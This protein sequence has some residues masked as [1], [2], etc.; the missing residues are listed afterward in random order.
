RAVCISNLKQI[1][2]AMKM[3]SQDYRE[4]FPRTSAAALS[5]THAAGNATTG[6]S[7]NLLYPKYISAEKTFICPSD[8][9][10]TTE[11]FAA[12]EVSQLG[13]DKLL[14]S[15]GCSYAYAMAC[16]EQTSVDT[17]LAVDKARAVDS[18]YTTEA[19]A[20]DVA[21]LTSSGQGGINHKADGVNALYVGGHV[22][23]IP[24]SRI[25][26]AAADFPNS[27]YATGTAGWVKNP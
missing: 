4:F 19:T 12:E 25:F 27:A 8:L 11:A 23:W 1:G 10:A 6:A 9:T 18:D 5:V 20:W 13:G 15:T 24:K 16:N 2:L 14:D 22:K 21:Q 3:Y 17:V 7:F 26:R